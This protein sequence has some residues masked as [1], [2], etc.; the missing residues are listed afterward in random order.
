MVLVSNPGRGKRVFSSPK[1]S[2]LAVVP[3]L[4]PFEWVLGALLVGDM[5][6]TTPPSGC[7]H[8]VCGENFTFFIT[9]IFQ[10]LIV[11]SLTISVPAM[12]WSVNHL[13]LGLTLL[14]SGVYE[15][16]F[17]DPTAKIE[18]KIQRPSLQT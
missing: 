16:L 9:L 7:P 10:L 17:K 3:T 6:L 11:I 14:E 5:R 1:T 15:P 18:R 13:F 12:K 2:I 4:F 8:G